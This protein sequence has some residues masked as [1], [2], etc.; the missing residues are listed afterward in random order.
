MVDK[1]DGGIQD[2]T[3]LDL[4][5]SGSIETG[6]ADSQKLIGSVS[7]I[8]SINAI[9]F[10]ELAILFKALVDMIR[11]ELLRE[12]QHVHQFHKHR[13]CTGHCDS[14]PLMLKMML[15]SSIFVLSGGKFFA[16]G[17]QN[18]VVNLLLNEMVHAKDLD[19]NKLRFFHDFIFDWDDPKLPPAIK[20]LR[21]NPFMPGR[22]LFPYT[23]D[24]YSIAFNEILIRYLDMS[25]LYKYRKPKLIK[26][27]KPCKIISWDEYYSGIHEYYKQYL[28]I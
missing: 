13:S 22:R 26:R 5:I 19:E 3:N 25:P 4:N 20:Q 28:V 14:S 9:K 15:N 7:T 24:S 8:N 16:N 1:Y 21:N 10:K 27:Y 6:V 11:D 12:H 2:E 23:S 18:T 17:H